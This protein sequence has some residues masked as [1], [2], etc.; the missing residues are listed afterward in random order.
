MGNEFDR[1]SKIVKKQNNIVGNLMKIPASY[2]SYVDITDTVND[3]STSLDEFTE[4]GKKEIYEE[5][6]NAAKK[7]YDQ[8]GEKF[9]STKNMKWQLSLS[10]I[11]DTY[12]R[13]IG[14]QTY[15][16]LNISKKHRESI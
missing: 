1:L 5:L 3:R 10:F 7:D 4:K 14:N 12:N 9:F 2:L 8:M 13:R 16:T 11:E 6:R 15:I